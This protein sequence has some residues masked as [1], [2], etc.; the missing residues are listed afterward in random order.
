MNVVHGRHRVRL[1]GRLGVFARI[2]RRNGAAAL[3]DAIAADG[4]REVQLNLS[5]LGL[6][7]IAGSGELATLDPASVQAAFAARGL[8][9]WG[10]SAT[11]NMAPP[12]PGRRERETAAAADFIARLGPFGAVAATLCTGTRDPDNIWRAHPEN[13]GRAAWRD[14][15]SSLDVLL[16][17]AAAAGDAGIRLGI[18]PEPGNV[19]NGTGAALRLVA[20]LG[21][22]ARHVGFILDPANLVAGRPRESHAATIDRAFESLGERTICLH[23]KD[24]AGWT[25]VLGTGPGGV[26]DYRHVLA[27]WRELPRPVPVIVQDATESE[28]GAVASLLLDTWDTL[29]D[30]SGTDGPRPAG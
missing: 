15:R 2:Y 21:A 24:P 17:A 8:R 25:A 6:P 27:R 10:V 3:A 26:V 23:A 12:Q 29:P 18:E 19:V 4:F 14:F 9:I 30:E 13:S 16:G 22:D 7:T 5:G 11:Y 28:A 1:A 20:E